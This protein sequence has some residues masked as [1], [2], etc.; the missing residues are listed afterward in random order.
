[1]ALP[2]GALAYKFLNNAQVSE[3]HKQLV[4]ATLT[5]LKYENMKDQIKNIFSDPINFSGIVQG[6]QS[7]KV[8]PTYHQDVFY[9]SSNKFFLSRTGSFNPRYRNSR[10]FDRTNDG[11]EFSKNL[12]RSTDNQ[13]FVRK[14]NLLDKNSEILKC[15]VCGSIY[16]WR[17]QCPDSYEN[18]TK[19]KDESQI[20]LFGEC[21]DTLIGETLSMAVID[22]GCA[23]TVCGQVWLDCY[24]QFLSNEDQQSV[25]EEKSETSFGFGNGKV[26]KSIK[27]VTLPTFFANKT[28]L[29]STEIIENDIPLLLRKDAMK[30]TKTYIDFSKD[31][32]IIFD[33]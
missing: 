26:L 1:M 17:K 11:R 28:V 5:E 20:A 4:R 14:T 2:D 8:E 6:E 32:I 9:S 13:E 25:R 15:N 30:K 21:M 29:L 19:P 12:D 7:I 3:Q 33:E 31:K 22:S 24:S 16:H 18:K 23:K 10:F 27:C